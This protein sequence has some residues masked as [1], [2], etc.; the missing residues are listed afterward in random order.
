MFC[1]VVS[2]PNVV[3]KNETASLIDINGYSNRNPVSNS[4]RAQFPR[5]SQHQ[6]YSSYPQ[7]PLPPAPY[8]QQQSSFQIPPETRRIEDSIIIRLPRGPDGSSGFLLKR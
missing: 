4:T 7:P 2:S 5:H 3:D 8:L 1:R 6:Q